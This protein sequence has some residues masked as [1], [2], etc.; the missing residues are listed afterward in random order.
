MLAD[1][2]QHV[3]HRLHRYANAAGNG[4]SIIT[5]AKS[6]MKITAVSMPNIIIWTQM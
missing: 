2:R 1:V 3:I 5:K 4:W 6:A